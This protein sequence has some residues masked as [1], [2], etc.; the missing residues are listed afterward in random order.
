MGTIAA[1]SKHNI[2]VQFE[3]YVESFSI[4]D[5]QQYKIE[6]RVDKKWV[7]LKIK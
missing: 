5:F 6:V 3:N 2:A 1:V 7:Q 4:A